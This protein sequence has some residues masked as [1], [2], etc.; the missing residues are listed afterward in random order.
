MINF[1]ICAFM[2]IERLSASLPT[3]Q[4][5]VKKASVERPLTSPSMNGWLSQYADG[6]MKQVIENRVG[7][8][9][10]TQEEANQIDDGGI[11]VYDCSYMGWLAHVTIFGSQ[12]GGKDGSF[13][14][15]VVDC[16]NPASAET[17]GTRAFFEQGIIA[18]VDARIA[19][20]FGFVGRGVRATVTLSSP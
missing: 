5:V 11:A 4:E 16:A 12:I 2:M 15:R 7:Y 18:E 9:W 6:V 3:V 19:K 17:D 14:G 13:K 10:I 1:C 20:R 8:G